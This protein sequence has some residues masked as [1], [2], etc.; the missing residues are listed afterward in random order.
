MDA[1]ENLYG[2]TWYGGGEL[3]CPA[4]KGCGTIYQ[5]RPGSP[6][7]EE[8]VIHRFGSFASDGKVP[9]LGPLAIDAQ[10]N[11]YGVTSQGGANLCVD[12]GCGT[13][14]KL[15]PVAAS[16]GI[17]WIETILYNFVDGSSGNGPGGNVII[18]G[19]GNLY[20]TTGY[21]GSRQCGCGV[22]YELSPNNGGWKYTVLHTFVGPDGDFPDANLTLGRDGNLYG[23]TADG[24]AYY[25]G[26]VFQIQIAQ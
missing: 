18:D 2:A 9:G 19:A 26:V 24:G 15:T 12:V 16:T 5:L 25:G 14:F 20:G 13:I 1:R 7:W 23:T 10:G 22:V 3:A 8:H 6:S 11:L 17:V 21:G 4:N